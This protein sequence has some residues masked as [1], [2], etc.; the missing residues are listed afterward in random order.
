MDNPAWS[1]LSWMAQT[2]MESLGVNWAGQLVSHW[3]LR[4]SA[5]TGLTVAMT[6]LKLPHMM[7]FTGEYVSCFSQ[8]EHIFKIFRLICYKQKLIPMKEF[9]RKRLRKIHLF[10]L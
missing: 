9:T 4:P 5:S 10:V 7:A 1:G 6:I 2:V 3:T 8:K